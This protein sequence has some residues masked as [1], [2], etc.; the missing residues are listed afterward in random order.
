MTTNAF[1]ILINSA[2][3]YVK[4]AEFFASQGG[5]TEPWGKY[6]ECIEA[7]S[8]YEARNKGIRLRRRRFPD[9]HLTTGE[10]GE[11]PESYWPE[12]IGH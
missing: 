9:S 11:A 12:A 7:C 3:V 10:R 8:F 4:G 5:L 1:Y 6:W 2:G